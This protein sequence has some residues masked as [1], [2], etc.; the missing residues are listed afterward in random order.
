MRRREL[1]PRKT[2]NVMKKWSQLPAQEG[3]EGQAL[4][5]LEE[6]RCFFSLPSEALADFR[7]AVVEACLNALE[8]GAPPVEVEVKGKR[9]GDVVTVCVLVRDHGPGFHP[10]NIPQ[11]QLPAK[12]RSDRKR[13]WG[14]AIMQRFTDRL[15]INSRSGLTEVRLSLVMQVQ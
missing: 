4:E 7:L 12:L 1:I 8:H 14:L 9:E 3:A 13:G 2:R 6:V 5:L 15:E 11:P 10:E